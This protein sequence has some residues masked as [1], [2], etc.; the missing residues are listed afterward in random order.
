MMALFGDTRSPED[1]VTATRN[2]FAE[3][4]KTYGG[5]TPHSLPTTRRLTGEKILQLIR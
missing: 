3:L 4:A 5:I 1:F 2:R